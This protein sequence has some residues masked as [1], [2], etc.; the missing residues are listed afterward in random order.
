MR[1]AC[2]CHSVESLNLPAWPRIERPKIDSLEI[3]KRGLLWAAVFCL[4]PGA[5][6]AQ[7]PFINAGPDSAFEQ[8]DFA[9]IYLDTQN[10][11]L[12]HTA[13]VK[14]Q[15]QRLI[16]SGVLSALDLEAPNKAVEEFNRASSLMKAQNSKEAIVYLQKAIAAYPKFVSAHNALG[17]AYLD[18]ED[19]RAKGEFE[20]AA[21][22][23]DKFPGSFLH[24]GLLALSANDF[25]SAQAALEKAASLSPKDP[26]TL[27]ALAFAQNGDHQYEQTLETVKR[28]HALEHKGLA[29][30]HYIAAASA[31]A[32]RNFEAMQSELDLFLSEDPTNPLAPAARKN[33]DILIQR[34]N[35]AAQAAAGTNSNAGSSQGVQTFP[36]SDRL[37][38]ELK[39]VGE[40]PNTAPASTAGNAPAGAN[41]IA[42]NNM[43]ANSAPGAASAAPA[44]HANSEL[45]ALPTVANPAMASAAA[46]AFT[47][48]KVVDE[49]A[50]FFAVSSHGHMVSNLQLSDIQVLDDDKP[51]E[52]IVQFIPQ[53][54]LPLRLGL[55]VD[56][57]GSVQER[58]GFEKKAAAKFLEKVLTGPSD[59]GFVVG[60]ASDST[61]TQDFASQPAQLAAGVEKLAIGGGTSLFD[62]VSLGCWKL[63][64]YPEQERVARVL[65]VLSDG[66]DNSSHR[67]L[68]QAIEEA[69]NSGVTIYTVSTS[70]GYDAKTD[71][72]RILQVLAERSGGEALFPGDM[73]TLDRSFDHLRELIRS[74]YLLSYKAAGFEPNGKYRTVH[75]TAEKD[76]K[77]L[78]V[79]ARKGYYARVEAPQH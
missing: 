78:Q 3:L 10:R 56:T 40:E 20:T 13:E 51:P 35:K 8:V 14:A 19:G 15:Q 38:A 60:F 5:V 4:F 27:A 46:A 70:I 43:T 29:N 30:V 68:K 11:D 55:L 34:K 24:L 77:R 66:E 65:V 73:Q 61:V 6:H 42:S 21:K 31:M 26:K 22:L 28:V 71:S 67:S 2:L 41:T 69:E 47:I 18:Q 63:A 54:K 74:R 49:S 50:L 48:H 79:H 58:F 12:K 23:D 25:S 44:S 45:T 76:G 32:L 9:Q 62:A 59:L 72:D 16:D 17:L 1:I 33:L 75:I 36:N 53:S 57:S 7:L 64:A 52:K 37:K 39:A